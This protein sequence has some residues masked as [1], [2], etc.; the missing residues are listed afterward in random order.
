MFTTV[1][2]S[3]TLSGLSLRFTETLVLDVEGEKGIKSLRGL[4]KDALWDA[5]DELFLQLMSKY[6][7]ETWLCS[8]LTTHPG[9]AP[10]TAPNPPRDLTVWKMIE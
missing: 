8:E 7:S 6:I 2:K 3:Y 10:P 9:C 5:K 1:S 4:M